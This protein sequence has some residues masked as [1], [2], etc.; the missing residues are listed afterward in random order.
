M[1]LARCLPVL[2]IETRAF[3]CRAM[4]QYTNSRASRALFLF[5]SD[6]N[7]S[8]YLLFPV[9]RTFDEYQN[10]EQNKPNESAS[11]SLVVSSSLSLAFSLAPFTSFVLFLCVANANVRFLRR[12][13]SCLFRHSAFSCCSFVYFPRMSASSRIDRERLLPLQPTSFKNKRNRRLSPKLRGKQRM[14]EKTETYVGPKCLSIFKCTERKRME[15]IEGDVGRCG[16]VGRLCRQ[17][18]I[19]ESNL[20]LIGG[21]AMRPARDCRPFAGA[22]TRLMGSPNHARQ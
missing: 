12:S 11:F 16:P 14:K 4:R 19:D 3:S 2:F 21:T 7:I 6:L 17:S 22:P 10:H 1:A 9:G 18:E 15:I 20:H 5:N 8:I 13:P